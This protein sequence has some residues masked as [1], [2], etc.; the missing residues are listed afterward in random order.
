MAE[1]GRKETATSTGSDARH[2]SRIHRY[3]MRTL[4]ADYGRGAVG[5]GISGAF[6]ALSPVATYSMVLFG[7]LTGLFLLFLLRTAMRQRLRIASDGAGIAVAGSSR[8]LAWSDLDELR[9]H[10]YAV[11]RNKGNGWMA[12]TLGAGGQRL[13]FD[14]TLDGFEEIVAQAFA[15]ARANDVGLSETTRANLAAL[16]HVAPEPVGSGLSAAGAG[17]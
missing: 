1:K 12:L 10:Y 9:L 8:R 17:R 6:W 16:G 7:G 4:L 14:S 15:A 11:R 13:K 5:A 2:M 3:P